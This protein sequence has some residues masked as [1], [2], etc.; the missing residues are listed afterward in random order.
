ML[1]LERMRLAVA[2]QEKKCKSFT[3]HM[4]AEENAIAGIEHL[5]MELKGSVVMSQS[6]WNFTTNLAKFHKHEAGTS[7]PLFGH[8][9]LTT[10]SDAERHKLY[11]ASVNDEKTIAELHRAFGVETYDDALAKTTW[12]H[13]H[14]CSVLQIRY[15]STQVLCM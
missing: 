1:Q 5:G 3:E 12:E 13:C 9:A 8:P 15:R 6:F 11:F 7:L 2:E 14:I 4:T 10:Y